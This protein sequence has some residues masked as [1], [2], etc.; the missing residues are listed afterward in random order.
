MTSKIINIFIIFGFLIN[1]FIPSSV[2]ADYELGE[3]DNSVISIGEFNNEGDVLLTK[4]IE[5]T[6]NIGEYKVTFDIKGKPVSTNVESKKDSYTV[7]VLDASLSMKGTKWN[8]AKEAAINFSE[9]L[10]NDSDKNY[11]ALVTFNGTGYKL[12]DFKN[13]KFSSD[14]FG[15]IYYY[16]NYYEGLSKAYSY[17]SNIND[18]SAI[19]NIVFI[20]DGEPNH[21]NYSEIL[22]TIK[23]DN[24]N[25][26]TLAYDLDNNSNAY[27]K[28]LNISTNNKVYEVSS[29]DINEKLLT[30]A[31]EIIKSN[32]GSNAVITD[33]IGNDFEF[34]SG[35]VIVNDKKVDINVGD[36]IN[37]NKSYSFIIKIDKELDTGWYPT[38]NGY[39]LNYID[40][41]NLEKSLSTNKSATVYWI[42]NK[43]NLTINY[44]ND[45]SMFKTVTKELNKDTNINNKVLDIDNNMENGYY[46]NY[47]SKN[48]FNID[49]DTTIDIYYKKI[50]N[51]SYLVNYYKDNE[52]F[53]TLEYNNIEYGYIPTYEELD[54][55][56]YSIC[57]VNNNNPIIDNN[58]IIDVYYCRNNYKY[59]VKYYYDNILDSEEELVASFNDI[60]TN[61]SDKIK[62]GYIIDYVDTIPLNITEKDNII[63]VYYK[64]KDIKYTVNYLDEFNNKIAKSKVVIGKYND[65][66]EEEYKKFND[67]K[68]ISNQLYNIKLD[69]NTKDIN[70][71]YQLKQGNITVQ[72]QDSNGNKISE[73]TIITGNYHDNYSILKKEIDG[74]NYI[75]DL[76]FIEGIIDEDNKVITLK[77]EKE[78]ID[79]VMAPLTGI[80]SNNNLF[81]IYILGIICLLGIKLNRV[82]RK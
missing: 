29:N 72:Y 25:I 52:L 56:G 33:Y 51:L 67:Y 69:D 44:Y 2:F 58:T 6:D 70:F 59:K 27:N 24:I 10:V 31:N 3:I 46:L 13:E 37:S 76:N 47:I 21:D 81:I 32:A 22:K 5:K 50:D 19:K 65:I 11:I 41:N 74:Y 60:I 68:L 39:T 48:N 20:S 30:I 16:T 23:D 64:L 36:I 73:D 71:Y 7:F 66:V 43:V 61:Y 1:I 53:N 77:Y 55:P 57:I 28:L 12:R 75:D 63:N 45:N 54:I 62:E 82:L 4:T 9:S 15:N 34:V 18:E 79:D 14:I 40:S 78:L 80:N 42:N 17:I 35:N 26:Y 38:N 49:K 8:K